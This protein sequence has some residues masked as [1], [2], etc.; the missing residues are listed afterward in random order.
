MSLILNDDKFISLVEANKRKGY[1]R[2]ADFLLELE[3]QHHVLDV[4]PFLPASDNSFHQYN[5]ATLVGKGAWRDL[6]EGRESTYGTMESIT[7]PVQIF[8]AES[9]ISDD[10]LHTADNFQDTRDSENLLVATGLVDDFM[11]A[12]I[13]S[14][15]TDPKKMKGC[16]YYRPTLGDYC[17]D[18]GGTASNS[19]TSFY[20]ANMGK[21]GV[22]VRYNPKLTGGSDGIGLK[23]VD[24]GAVWTKDN[25]GRDMKVW[26][27]TYDLTAALELRQNKSLVRIANVDPAGSIKLELLIKAIMK[28][29]TRD[30]AVIFA[31]KCVEE[32]LINMALS[33]GQ[34]QMRYEDVENFGPI[35]KV[36][37]VPV[38]IEEAIQTNESK[39][40]A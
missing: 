5:Q 28:L 7:T 9:N 29:P 22:N 26:K 32:M 37:G 38:L 4:L 30:G 39:V 34:N 2:N 6:N 21:N 10:V 12:F 40:T 36:M 14:D 8:S 1:D 31:P 24:E 27:T 20:V 18:A 16:A 25:K 11:E 17:L 13:Y 19:L 23:I 33:V 15:G 3:K 35:L